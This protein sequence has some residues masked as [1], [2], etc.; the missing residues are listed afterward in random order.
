MRERARWS[1]L[2][3]AA[4][5]MPHTVAAS[6]LLKLQDVSE[7]VGHAV[8][9]VQAEQ[10][11]LCAADHHFLREQVLVDPARVVGRVQILGEVVPERA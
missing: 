2:R 7:H 10:H 6:S 1:R 11:A 3:N 8:F 5:V 4:G 9:A